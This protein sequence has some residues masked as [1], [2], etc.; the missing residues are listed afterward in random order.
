MPPNS[1]EQC[2]IKQGGTTSDCGM[3]ECACA[4]AAVKK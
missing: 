2:A 3:A 4:A 1:T